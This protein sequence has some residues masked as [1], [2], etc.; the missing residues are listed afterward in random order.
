MGF[1]PHHEIIKTNSHWN[2][3]PNNQQLNQIN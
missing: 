2:Q 3:F 1:E